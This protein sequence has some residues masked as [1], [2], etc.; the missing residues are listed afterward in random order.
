MK[1]KLR[2]NLLACL[3]F[4]IFMHVNPGNAQVKQ[5]W[6]KTGSFE[7]EKGFTVYPDR[8][9]A[10]K[11]PNLIKNG[12]FKKVDQRTGNVD[13]WQWYGMGASP[14]FWNV[15]GKIEDIHKL[16]NLESKT[17]LIYMYHL[18]PELFLLS[19][20]KFNAYGIHTGELLK[21]EKTMK[22]ARPADDVDSSVLKQ[23]VAGLVT[24]NRYR[25]RFFTMHEQTIIDVI[26]YTKASDVDAL[27]GLRIS[28]YKP[29]IFE[30]PNAYGKVYD[31]EFIAKAK[32]VT[33][34]ML[35]YGNLHRKDNIRKFFKQEYYTF[36][37]NQ[38]CLDKSS[39]DY[40][41]EETIIG[42]YSLV[43]MGNP[44]KTVPDD[45]FDHITFNLAK[46]AEEI[47]KNEGSSPEPDKEAT[48]QRKPVIDKPAIYAGEFK[49]SDLADEQCINGTI[50]STTK[51]D[52]LVLDPKLFYLSVTHNYPTLFRKVTISIA[53]TTVFLCPQKRGYWCD[54]FLPDTLV[55]TIVA[56][57][58]KDMNFEGFRQPI[59]I[60]IIRDS[61]W[62]SRCKWVIFTIFGLILLIIYLYYLNHKSRFKKGSGVTTEYAT[63]SLR[64]PI[65]GFMKLR[66]RGLASWLNRWFN[67]FI[68]ES[69][70]LTFAQSNRTFRFI[71]TH[72]TYRIIV[73]KGNFDKKSMVCPNYDEED[74]LPTFELSEGDSIL[75][76]KVAN[77]P[78]ASFRITYDRRSGVADDIKLYRLFN[79]FAIF[80]AILAIL[81]FVGSLAGNSF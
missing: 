71:A 80:T 40:V 63:A 49:A 59:K 72:S 36:P 1:K 35:N 25:L 26:K 56:K 43:D 38:A 73:P 5:N 3:G 42:D 74:K 16:F 29:V 61:S 78:N 46:R 48:P 14:M 2:T 57:P 70:E 8:G 18:S 64:H 24:G 44:S 66:N 51:S 10:K 30:T 22:S 33:I 47:T 27:V 65:N 9:R 53:G 37:V 55:L 23:T 50:V 31:F 20:L 13:H 41:L 17:S 11:S 7:I 15:G 81:F 75:I 68:P 32:T 52:T 28:G 4:L 67:P 6:A 76:Q 34:A 62:W 60:K 39:S 45:F 58:K 77:I 19:T 79:G 21:F 54:C 69:R 12:D